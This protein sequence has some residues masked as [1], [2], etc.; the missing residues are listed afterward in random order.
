MVVGYSKCTHFP[1]FMGLSALIYEKCFSISALFLNFA[2][3]KISINGNIWTFQQK[4]E[5]NT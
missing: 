4:Q 3:N 5:R 2:I 1:I